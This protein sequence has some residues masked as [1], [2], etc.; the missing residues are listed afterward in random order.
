M[1]TFGASFEAMLRYVLSETDVP[2]P[3]FDFET[4]RPDM[5]VC[6]VFYTF[7]DEQGHE[8]PLD[9][10]GTSSAGPTESKRAACQ[11]ALKALQ[12]LHGLQIVDFNHSRLETAK[13]EYVSSLNAYLA[14]VVVPYARLLKDYNSLKKNWMQWLKL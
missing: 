5:Y 8:Y 10:C 1:P 3:R 14:N 2:E 7:R 9:I 12:R 4:E 6:R 11:A 13:M